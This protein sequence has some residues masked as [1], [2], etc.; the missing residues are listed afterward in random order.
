MAT[1]ES[2][3]RRT[4]CLGASLLVHLSAWAAILPGPGEEALLVRVEALEAPSEE[5]T[6]ESPRPVAVERPEERGMPEPEEP[7]SRK[8]EPASR[9]EEPEAPIERD[10]MEKR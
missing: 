10:R 8:K 2:T 5:E 6:P 3:V 7:A 4:V 9:K 1:V